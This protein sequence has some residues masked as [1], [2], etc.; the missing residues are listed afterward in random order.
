MI[1]MQ[2]KA[3]RA[4]GVAVAVIAAATLGGSQSGLDVVGQHVRMIGPMVHQLGASSAR[5]WLWLI[6]TSIVLAALPMTLI[7]RTAHLF[8]RTAPIESRIHINHA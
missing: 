3:L 4:L 7:E 2:E 8:T 1:V 6:V 5:Q